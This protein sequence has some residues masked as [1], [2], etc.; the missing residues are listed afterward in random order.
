MGLQCSN[1]DN[2]MD[3][4]LINEHKNNDWD[5]RMLANRPKNT[6]LTKDTDK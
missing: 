4:N 1:I 2:V 3:L 6:D 5:L